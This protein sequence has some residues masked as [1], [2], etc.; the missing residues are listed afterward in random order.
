MSLVFLKNST[1]AGSD[2]H[3]L[4]YSWSNN[5]D[6]PLV[7]PPDSQVAYISS[8]MGRQ[9]TIILTDADHM[10]FQIGN[11][12]LNIPMPMYFTSP[13]E[14]QETW[15]EVAARVQGNEYVGITDFMYDGQSGGYTATYNQPTDQF[16]ISLE[17]RLQPVVQDVWA[18]QSGSLS[19]AWSGLNQTGLIIQDPT[20]NPNANVIV[21]GALAGGV[22]TANLWNCGWG[23]VDMGAGGVLV[24]D[25][26]DF[27]EDNFSLARSATGI[28]RC[29]YEASSNGDLLGGALQI[30]GTNNVAAPG[31]V[32]TSGVLPY[33]F[34]LNSVQC[35]QIADAETGGKF[36]DNCSLNG[37]F[38]AS[39]SVLAPNVVQVRVTDAQEIVVEIMSNKSAPTP[40]EPIDLGA[41]GNVNAA[42][43]IATG[44]R[45][46][47]RFNIADWLATALNQPQNTGAEASQPYNCGG[48]D[49][50]LTEKIVFAIQWTSPYTFQVLAGT[51][52]DEET[53][54]W[55]GT[56]GA[57]ANAGFV[58]VAYTNTY[59]IIYDS[60]TGGN[61]SN[62]L[63]ADV[64]KT[65]FVPQY[66]GDLGMCVYTDRRNR[67]NFRGNFD[68]IKC[69]ADTPVAPYPTYDIML[70]GINSINFSATPSAYPNAYHLK[71]YTFDT[72]FN[73]LALNL[74]DA[75][76]VP[77][78]P[79]LPITKGYND[80]EIRAVS[81]ILLGP[82]GN[83]ANYQRWF[84]QP[85]SDLDVLL[86][87]APVGTEPQVKTGVLIGLIKEGDD[88]QSISSF[89]VP[90]D[91][92]NQTF[93]PVSGVGETDS[94]QSV[95]IQLTN[96][97]I[98]GRNGVTSTKTS[99]IG[100]VH[101]AKGALS[102]GTTRIFETYQPE[103]N[104]I[105]LNNAAEMTLNEL[106]VFVSDDS[107]APARFLVGKSDIVVMFRQKPAA[108]KGI[109]TQPINKFGLTPSMGATTIKM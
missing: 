73:A 109:S 34:G 13:N 52:F 11:T 14:E 88:G 28:K 90:N 60:Q 69:Y 79:Q 71:T 66:F 27:G 48:A 50:L 95:H 80:A 53:G 47:D 85:N 78:T 68:V 81:G 33:A 15:G 102:V 108:D 77:V 92:R 31:A 107:N 24:G 7:L 30:R 57:T 75:F 8:T 86:T 74:I 94:V 19:A 10:W 3:M 76:Q 63:V 20:I 103:K 97:P 96:L 41:W 5:F 55:E 82:A 37:G 43:N 49:V 105:D 39:S 100:V 4:P 87:F 40:G 59:T 67:I 18:N 61:F 2:G 70:R 93:K 16:E 64:N 29:V 25:L 9:K 12:E 58:G 44:L 54:R 36:I 99:T 51:G 17:Q 23:Q 106:R 32:A 38:G 6:T 98:N 83:V 72:I 91:L 104:W 45:Q 56:G 22:P 21:S 1:T 65:L 89:I 46:V 35:I 101:N 26:I 62:G 84:P 42:E